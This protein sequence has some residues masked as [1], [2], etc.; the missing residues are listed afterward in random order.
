M[1]YLRPRLGKLMRATTVPDIL[2][3]CEEFFPGEPPGSATNTEDQQRQLLRIKNL[4]SNKTTFNNI[5]PCTDPSL[6]T[7][8]V[9]G[10]HAQSFSSTGTRTTSQPSWTSTAAASSTCPR[11]GW[12]VIVRVWLRPRPGRQ[13]PTSC[14]VQGGC[15]LV[16]QKGQTDNS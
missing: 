11:Q 4:M 12:A 9:S 15:A 2:R 16:L 7:I 8:D 10:F 3:H 5:I 6:Q 13:L 1:L 14:P